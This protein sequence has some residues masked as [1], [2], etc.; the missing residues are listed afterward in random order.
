MEKSTQITIYIN[1]L[2]PETCVNIINNLHGKIKLGHRVS[3]F[4]LVEESPT[5]K[6]EVQEETTATN[7]Q[8]VMKNIIVINPPTPLSPIIDPVQ[9]TEDQE[10]NCKNCNVSSSKVR[11]LSK[12]WDDKSNVYSDTEYTS[13][14][15]GIYSSR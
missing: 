3:V 11:T 6:N 2:N 10:L 8:N 12:F 13:A 9:V 1:D 15:R 5:K 14:R 7:D 4:S